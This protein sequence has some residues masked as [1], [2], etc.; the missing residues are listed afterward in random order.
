MIG[1]I[2]V[3]KV[4]I[5]TSLIS[6]SLV[7]LI[8]VFYP[9]SGRLK[10]NLVSCLRWPLRAASRTP[11]GVKPGSPSQ[12]LLKEKQKVETTLRNLT[13]RLEEISRENERLRTLLA[14]KQRSPRRMVAVQV[15]G[16]DISD[17]SR[18]ILIDRGVKEGIREGMPVVAGGALAGKVIE[19]GS[20]V[21]KV[22]LLTDPDSRVACLIQESRQAGLVAGTV[23]GKI[24]MKYIDLD[25]EVKPGELVI[26]SGFGEIYPK[27]LVVGKVEGVMSE[28]RGLYKCAR[29]L[30]Q[31]NF[32]QLEEVLVIVE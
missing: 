21:S 32:S 23:G 10:M 5:I 27:G 20:R 18:T 3:R 29:I 30:P 26:T 8:A 6:V 1:R 28:S 22:M 12:K 15:I 16:R 9:V 24:L 14:F 11:A 17:W 31:V 25:A 4:I 2:Q 19:A 7:L 13:S